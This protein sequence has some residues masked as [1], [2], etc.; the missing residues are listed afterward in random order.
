MRLAAG[1]AR[2]GLAEKARSLYAMLRGY[3]AGTA[4]AEAYNNLC[5]EQ[6]TNGFDLETALD[7]CRQAVALR[8]D[9][10]IVDSLAFTELRLGR[11]AEALADYD[12]ALAAAPE[13]LEAR[14]GRGIARLRRGDKPGGEA[15]LAATRERAPELADKFAKMGLTP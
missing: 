8:N 3:A 11:Y 9:P 7:D 12:K 4:N 1:Y 14:Y 2:T 5:Y 6:A 13:M 15:D 10:H